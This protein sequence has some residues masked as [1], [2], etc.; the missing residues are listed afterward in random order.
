MQKKLIN[1][2]AFTLLELMVAFVIFV[3]CSVVLGRTFIS[4]STASKRVVLNYN[5]DTFLEQELVESLL[6]IKKNNQA[7][8]S[9]LNKEIFLNNG[10][11]ANYNLN[12]RPISKDNKLFLLEYSLNYLN[13]SKKL[14]RV[15]CLKQ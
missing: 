2:I 15:I 5:V 13:E 10:V 6:Y 8:L 3:T 1:K 4:L 14:T 11:V 9:I 12:V 7:P